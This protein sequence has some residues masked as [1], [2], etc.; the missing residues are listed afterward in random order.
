MLAHIRKLEREVEALKTKIQKRSRLQ[1]RRIADDIGGREQPGSGAP[2]S[3]KG[4]VRKTGDLRVEAKTTSAKTFIL[5]LRE[6]LKIR[7]EALSG[8]V[9]DWAMQVEFQDPLGRNKKVAVIDW[10]RFLELRGDV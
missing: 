10:D 8:G 3:A 9:E 7:D 4:D 1:E 2:W 6:I 5:K